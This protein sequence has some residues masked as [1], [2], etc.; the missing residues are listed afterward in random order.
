MNIDDMYVAMYRCLAVL[1]QEEPDEELGEYLMSIN[2][3]VFNEANAADPKQR[4]QFE[5]TV[6]GWMHEDDVS[7]NTG[8]ELVTRYLNENSKFGRTFKKIP[9]SDWLSLCYILD[10]E[11]T[12]AVM[13]ALKDR[14]AEAGDGN[15]ADADIEALFANSMVGGIMSGA[16][17]MYGMSG[18]GASMSSG[19]AAEKKP[20][21]PN[22]NKKKKKEKKKS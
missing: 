21:H 2:P 22:K 14:A 18:T 1:H 3:Y 12:A 11:K 5:K 9:L 4:K 15:S 10:Q 17:A 19:K 20:V 13:R 7:E 6:K 16:G 8:Y